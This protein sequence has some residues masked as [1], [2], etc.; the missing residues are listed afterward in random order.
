VFEAM[1]LYED[2]QRAELHSKWWVVNQSLLI[3]NISNKILMAKAES[4]KE[5]IDKVEKISN[6]NFVVIPWHN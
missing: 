5:W 6:G 2:L 4:E 3:T 1:R